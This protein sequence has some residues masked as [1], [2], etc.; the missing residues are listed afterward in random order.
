M[1][2]RPA[3]PEPE[4]GLTYREAGVDLAAAERLVPRLRALA[5]A[6]RRPEVEGEIGGFGGCFL[7]PQGFRNPVL[8]AGMDGVGTKLDLLTKAGRHAVAGWDLVAMCVNDVLAQGAQPL[9]FLD[10]VA[11]GKLDTGIVEGVVSGVA[12][13]CVECGCALLGGETAEMPGFY[14]ESRYDL[15]GCAVGVVEKERLIDGRAIRPGDIL[16]GLASSG[17]HSN[18]FS[19]IRRVLE[20]AGRGLQDEFGGPGRT[21]GDALLAPTRLYVRPVLEILKET[22]VAGI[23]HITGGG[24]RGNLQRIIPEGCRAVV[25]WGSWP[26]P[27]VFEFLR[28]AGS[29]PREEMEDVFNLGVGLI[30]AVSPGDAGRTGEGLQKLGEAPFAMGR[31][32]EGPP[33]GERVVLERGDA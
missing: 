15:A 3:P 26:V 16:L 31:I 18:G 1:K 17:P 5:R 29:I 30:L 24:I 21:L 23:A 33:D 28:Q 20:R 9:F 25:E 32:E 19:L 8:V 11:A 12:D 13:A 7:L 6:T 4:A 14:P 10:Y 22:A 27:P 2:R